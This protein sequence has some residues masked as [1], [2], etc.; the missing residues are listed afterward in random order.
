MNLNREFPDSASARN[1]RS[2]RSNP[3][4]SQVQGPHGR[5]WGQRGRTPVVRVTGGSNKRSL[6]ALIAIK[7]GC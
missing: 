5:T 1:A 2:R 6:A 3:A 7:P 4:Q